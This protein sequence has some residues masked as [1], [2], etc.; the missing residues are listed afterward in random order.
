[1]SWR[2]SLSQ[3]LEV[4]VFPNGKHQGSEDE[5]SVVWELN[6]ECPMCHGLVQMDL[7]RSP[8]PSVPL[9]TYHRQVF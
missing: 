5:L 2:W 7:E 6:V 3:Q 1:M 8:L 9:S 4:S